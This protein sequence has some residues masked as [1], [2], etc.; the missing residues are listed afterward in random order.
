MRLSRRFSPAAAKST[1]A[2]PG[3]WL[4]SLYSDEGPVVER[5]GKPNAL[6]HG[7]YVLKCRAFKV[8]VVRTM[9]IPDTCSRQG[10]FA[11]IFRQGLAQFRA[12]IL[13]A[14][15]LPIRWDL[16]FLAKP[17]LDL[18][19]LPDIHIAAVHAMHMPLRT[20]QPSCL[21]PSPCPR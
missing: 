14:P 5:A 8:E 15:S 21:I 4:G 16:V 6:D 11:Y 7:S 9:R 2:I 10:C 20:R 17:F 13:A 1:S 3:A 18:H 19:P 12:E